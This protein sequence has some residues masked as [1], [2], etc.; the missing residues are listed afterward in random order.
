MVER[1]R[2][3]VVDVEARAGDRALTDRG[4]SAASSTIGPA[5]VDQKGRRFI[6]E[7]SRAP[8][9]L[10]VRSLSTRWML[11]T[12]DATRAR[13]VTSVGRLGGARGGE[14][15]LQ[16]TTSISNARP[17]LATRDPAASPR[18]RASCVQAEPQVTAAALASR[19][20][21]SDVT[22][23]ARMSP[24]TARPS[25]REARGAQTRSCAPRRATSIDALRMPVVTRS[26]SRQP[27]QERPGNGVR[28]RIAPPRR[29]RPVAWRP[30]PCRSGDRRRR[31]GPCRRGDSSSR[32]C[33]G[34]FW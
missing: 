33:D 31:R 32:P 16:A 18:R 4:D 20:S 26:L 5:S 1:Q 19:R 34:D 23:S 12:S 17:I 27:L 14:I 2:L 7:S 10:R 6:S 28:S 22:E 3:L 8:N 21:S 13:L 25:G 11:T 15:W 24:T 29:S 30:R 9:S